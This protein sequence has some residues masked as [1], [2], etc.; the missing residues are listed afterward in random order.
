MI[1]IIAGA[2]SISANADTFSAHINSAQEVPMNS[3]TGTG[4][5]R[6]N[7]N[8]STQTLSWT[9]FFTGLSSNQTA[10]H[11]HA[12]APVGSN[13]GVGVNLGSVG[14]TTGT[15]TGSMVISSTLRDQLRANLAYVNIHT[16]DNPG[17]EIR[18]QLARRRVVDYDGDGRTDYSVLR[19][20]AGTCPGTPRQITY[21]NRNS[22][23]ISSNQTIPWGDACT[24]FPS[25]GDY[26]GDGKDD[27]AVYRAGAAAGQQSTFLIL[28]SSDNTAQFV[29]YGLFGDQAV[30]RDY[31]GDGITDLAVFRRSATQTD[32]TTWFIRQ[33][34]SGV[35]R[36]ETFGLSGNGSST[37]DTPIPG[38]YDGD[39]KFDLAVY[40]FGLTPANNYIVKQS[41]NNAVIYT[42]WGNFTTDYIVPGDYDGDG[43]FEVAAARTG[44]TGTS[45]MVWYIRRSSDSVVTIQQWGQSSDVP[46]QGDY[47]GDGATDISVFRANNSG[48]NSAYFTLQSQFNTP[49]VNNWGVN[50]DFSVNTFDAR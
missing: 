22:L 38:D 49:L 50:G 26:D 43:K 19:F 16:S 1:A 29:A 5:A 46:S 41:S 7:Y 37:F 44:A 2:A 15:I 23:G 8:E 28:R 25:P 35:T 10:A 48:G 3:T 30:S 32:P 20:P 11:I 18:G 36:I 33:S 6:M 34:T 13:A 27:L 40:R 42:Q 39:G 9:V 21:W 47:N 17:G 14:G 24:D 45:P 4:W 31:D 12:A